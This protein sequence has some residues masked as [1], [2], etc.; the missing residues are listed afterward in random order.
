MPDTKGDVVKNKTLIYKVITDYI[1]K[2][3][4]VMILKTILRFQ[5]QLKAI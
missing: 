2:L 5:N 1:Q 3:R 4:C